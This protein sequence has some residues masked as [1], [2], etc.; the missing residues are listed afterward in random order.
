[1]VICGSNTTLSGVGGLTN[2]PNLQELRF[3]QSQL[4]SL[5]L[6]GCSNLVSIALVGTSPS[7]NMENAW[8]ND[9]AAVQPSMPCGSTRFSCNNQLHVFYF[10]LSPGTN[11]SSAAACSNLTHQAGVNGHW[12]LQHY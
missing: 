1:V 12:D 4:T 3:Y 11:D 7:T 10:P 9:L 5:S 8:F 2:Y 6:S